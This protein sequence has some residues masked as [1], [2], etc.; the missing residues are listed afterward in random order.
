MLKDKFDLNIP[1]KFLSSPVWNSSA[2]SANFPIF[3]K[4]ET[5]DLTICLSAHIFLFAKFMLFLKAKNKKTRCETEPFAWLSWEN[6]NF[7]HWDTFL[8]KLKIW[9]LCW[10]YQTLWDSSSEEYKCWKFNV[11]LVN[12]NIAICSR[13]STYKSFVPL[14]RTVRTGELWAP[15]RFLASQ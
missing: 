1:L 3:N 12:A 9:T 11:S 2:L 4:E 14:T 5:G 15:I 7:H 8:S 13:I 6:C 10:S